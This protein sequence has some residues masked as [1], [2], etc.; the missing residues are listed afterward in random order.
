MTEPI[1]TTG[2]LDVSTTTPTTSSGRRRRLGAIGALGALALAVAVVSCAPPVQPPATTTTTSSTTTTAAPA[3]GISLVDSR[4]EDGWRWSF[5]RNHDQP[6]AVSGHQTFA[7][8]ARV[9]SSPSEP[10]PLWVRLRGGGVG[11]FD[12]SGRPRPNAANMR[13]N[14]FDSLVDFSD[15]NALAQRFVDEHEDAR[16]LSVSMCSHDLYAGTGED[17]PHNPGVDASGDPITTNGLTATIEAI[18]ATTALLETDDVVLHGTSAGGAGSFHVGW[19][20]ER[21]DTPPTAI[22]SDGGIVN[23]AWE[24]AQIDQGL[25]CARTTQQGELITQRW[26]PLLADPDNEPHLLVE[27]GELSAP[28][29]FVWN[30]GDNNTCGDDAMVCPMP[31]GSTSVMWSTR[32]KNEP[33]RATI[34][35]LPP[36]NPSESLGVCVDDPDRDGPCDQHVVTT[37]GRPNTDPALP[38]DYVGTI[39]D[40]VDLRLGD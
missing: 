2:G 23:R 24:Q 13:E 29:M 3:D 4:V 11:Y 1:D 26:D 32:C 33:L 8:G 28:V 35:S 37:A 18:D 38:T 39:V 30:Q 34:D 22:V 19:F 7:V 17:D 36:S 14:S 12:L 10:G 40:W 9:G 15:R 25:D 16:V 5:Y 20:L 27:R 31:D 21:R 6:C